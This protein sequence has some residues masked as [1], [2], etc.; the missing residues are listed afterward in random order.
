MSNLRNKLPL[1][2]GAALL[3]ALP[4]CSLLPQEEEELKPPL[5]KPVQQNFETAEVKKGSISRQLTAVASFVSSSMEQLVFNDSG[6]RL[7]S[8]DVKLGDKVKA[9]DIVAHL[10]AGDL[11]IRIRLQKLNVQKAEIALDQAKATAMG[12]PDALKL[13]LLD[14]EAA[15]IQLDSLQQ[16]FE[17]TKLVSSIDGVVTYIDSLQTGDEITAYRPVVTVSDPTKLQLVY[18]ASVTNDISPVQVGMKAE[19]KL[20]GKTLEGKVVQTPSSA[21]FT[22][23]K[24]LSER[25]AKRLVISADGIPEGV[26][27]GDTADITIPLEKRDDV[28]IIPRS[29][30]RSYLGRDYV[31]TLEGDSRREVDVEKG[32]VSSTEVEIRKG[33]KEGQKI[34]LSN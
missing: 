28:L 26:G 11:E 14:V 21:P 1:V 8:I 5:V 32:I 19:V 33:L 25:N 29:G 15:H 30:L 2:L 16:Q 18:E 27:I 17:K 12:D 6:G 23:D 7:K 20:K 10:D 3:L 4:G 31:Q 22:S 9:G 13:K 34:I 24:Q